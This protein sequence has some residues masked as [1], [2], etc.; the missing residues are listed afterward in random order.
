MRGKLLLL[1][2]LCLS[3]ASAQD[4][5]EIHVYEYES[6]SWKEYSVEAHLNFDPQGTPLRD[7]SLLPTEHQAHLTIE[8]TLGISDNFAVG[9]MFLNAWEPGNSPEFAGWRVLPH[10]LA[11][12][13]WNVPV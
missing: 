11:P 10:I 13:S 8:P 1:A 7:G 3:R 6:L 2:A 12:D 4:P 5:F 9:F